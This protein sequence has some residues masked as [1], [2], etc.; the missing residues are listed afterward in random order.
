MMSH[1]G[2][3]GEKPGFKGRISDSESLLLCYFIALD[4]F[5]SISNFKVLLNIGLIAEL[6]L[7]VILRAKRNNIL[8]V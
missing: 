8:Y 5:P 4:R 1:C 7:T 2:L 3:M 6:S